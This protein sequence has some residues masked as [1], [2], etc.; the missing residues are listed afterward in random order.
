MEA[1]SLSV[2]CFAQVATLIHQLWEQWCRNVF[3]IKVC[4]L[5]NLSGKNSLSCVFT[6]H[7]NQ[8]SV[9]CC[10]YGTVQFNTFWVAALMTMPRSSGPLSSG[11]TSAADSKALPQVSSHHQKSGINKI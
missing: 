8:K 3:G 7:V 1:R 6:V 5:S 10:V 9:F 4:V 11:P 2:W